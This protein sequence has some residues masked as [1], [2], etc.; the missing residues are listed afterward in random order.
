MRLTIGSGSAYAN[1]RLET[2]AAMADSGCV[3]YMGFDCLAE[4]TMA[5]AQIRRMN[6]PAA[7]QDERIGALVPILKS[8]LESGGRVVGNFG[9]A[10]PDAAAADFGAGLARLGI[11]GTRIGIIRGDD[12]RDTVV[13]QDLDLP[14]LGTSTRALGE[15]IVSANAYIGADPVVDCLQQDAQIVLGGRLADPSL[16]VGPI[17]HE[18]GWALD[19][20]DRVAQAT[21]AGHLLECGVHSTGGN[22]EDPPYRVVPDPHNLSFPFAEIDD[23]ELIVTKLDGTG[24][25]V[26]LRTTRTQLYYEIHDPT[27]Y[28]TPDVVADFSGVRLE[29][30]GK[31]RVRLSGARGSARPDTLKVLVG[32]DLG[33]KAVAEI[34]YGGPGCVDR[35]R[36]AEE[37]VRKRLEPIRDRI[38]E[39]R[40][41]LH[42]VNTLF[43]D[44]MRGGEPAE[45]RLRLAARALD[46]DVAKAAAYE[47][48]YLYFGPAGGG[49]VVTSVVPAIVVTPALLPRSEVPLS[50]EVISA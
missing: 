31:D 38:D 44:R 47:I 35:A 27:I 12:V 18:L 20:W 17:C 36:R 30:V 28:L 46:H 5:L 19:D 16:F 26:D 6:D 7:G 9:A 41:E 10:N 21:L 48:E 13:S 50:V 23:D 43:G 3:G 1:D 2:A 42:G 15:R 49:G 37:I 14:E 40:I 4:R 29:E 24:G 39:L 45:V 25:V 33:Y 34:S 11:T 22:F 8:F 32:V